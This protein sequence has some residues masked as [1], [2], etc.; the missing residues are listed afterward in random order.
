[1][2]WMN[3]FRRKKPTVNTEAKPQQKTTAL[4]PK[5]NSL[6]VENKD[7]S[8]NEITDKIPSAA[9]VER[10]NVAKQRHR[11]GNIA[12]AEAVYLEILEQEPEYADAHHMV[13]VVNLQKGQFEQAEKSFRQAIA[14][15]HSQTDFYSNLGNALAA[16]NR[17]D[18]AYE[19]FKQAITLDAN[20]FS[21]LGNAATALLTL[22]RSDEAKP[23]CLKILAA[24]PD[25][26]SALLNLASVH[27][28]QH[29]T[30]SAIAVIRK[31][32]VIEPDNVE[33]KIQLASNLELINQ[34][35]EAKLVIE[36]VVTLQPKMP[37][38]SLIRG[39]I[40][41]RQ[42]EL[43]GAEQSLKTAIMQGLSPKEQIEAFNQ[44]G[45]ALDASGKN[46]EAFKAFQQS[47]N[48]MA[49]V[50]ANDDIDADKFMNDVKA[51]NSYFSNDKL[52]QLSAKHAATVD[53]SPVF[54]VG[55]PRSGTTLMEQILKAH[56]QLVTTDE[57]SPLAIIINEIRAIAGAYPQG[58]ENLT[59]EDITRMRQ[60]YIDICHR[61]FDDLSTKRVVDKL[62]L[63]IV[64]L[65]LAKLLF[66]Q[67]R[68]IVA[69]RDPRDAC[70]SCFMQKFDLNN[71]MANFLDIEKTAAAYEAVMNLWLSYRDYLQG[72]WFEYKYED[73]V[74]DF[75]A[76]VTTV[77]EF[78]GVDWHED[79]NSYRQG[80]KN[81][82]ITTPSYRDV[83]APINR[84]ALARWQAYQPNLQ[85]ILPTLAPFIEVFEY[86]K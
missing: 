39:I 8:K 46:A 70:L 76:T 67:A 27:L 37:R 18:E 55:F 86:D 5:V 84:N 14:L 78:I 24:F 58:L 53:F 62:P 83:T 12:Q 65:G 2:S 31:G 74:A 60:H 42:K 32:I 6:A 4:T 16:Q 43:A 9:A 38:A 75:D 13:A 82:A 25:D 80:A 10:L 73:L 69:L 1:M 57:R 50:C 81:R 71:A 85:V 59:A 56:P 44:L 66:P 48:I 35:D 33:L 41:R 52:A 64:H 34:L 11:E 54:F 51:I 17:I 22:D 29:D 3:L 47:N 19:C 61:Y 49:K 40:L 23:L 21:A 72:S 15:D 28:A 68:I 63:N 7:L 30:H 45:L 77:L 20:N 26:I 36:E 79:I